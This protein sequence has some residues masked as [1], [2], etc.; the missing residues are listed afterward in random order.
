MTEFSRQSLAPLL[1]VLRTLRW[2]AIASQVLML[3]IA[4]Q[5]LHMQLAWAPAWSAVLLLGLFNLYA[6]WR[7]NRAIIV[8]PAEAFL[9]ILVDVVVL[10][11]IIGWTGGIANPFG[12]LFLL[13]IALA[14][15][16]MPLNWT[17][18]TAAVCVSGYVAAAVFGQPLPHMPGNAID[19]HLW[20]MA[21]NFIVSSAVVLLFSTRLIAAREQREQQ[22]ASIRE[23]F[24]RGEG[25]L[26]LA[27]HAA[28][29]AHELST[30][31]G[32]LTLL[33]E[34]A[35]A[36]PDI[37]V[38]RED[39]ATMRGLVEVCRERVRELA[40]PADPDAAS[41]IEL[42]RVLTHWQLVRPGI[43]LQRNR[44]APGKLL[45]DRGIGHLL[46]V[47]LNNA[48]DAGESNGR[49]QVDLTIHRTPDGL[50]GEIRDYGPGFSDLT[51]IPAL[52][53][54]SKPGGLGVGLAL[55]HATIERLGGSLSIQ[56]TGEGARVR[57][58]IPMFSDGDRH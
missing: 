2:L 44:D 55:S 46:L 6:G 20:G 40:Q 3:L 36:S 39:I 42:E 30:P 22:L 28:S 47:L 26:A 12:S 33:L 35:Q 21:A 48:A 1:K 51:L 15:L 9:H 23:R 37:P 45:V 10:A 27:T 5:V 43:R 19:L 34:D 29:V 38:A 11:W 52:L 18:G 16:A 14:A 58:E 54:S 32:T 53:T 8:R 17:L 50:H 31:L 49:H 13:P 25:I 57:F 24:A 4:G 41:E 56:S 7:C